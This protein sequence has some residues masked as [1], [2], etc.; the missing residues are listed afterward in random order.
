MNN[1]TTVAMKAF[2]P[3]LILSCFLF[4]LSIGQVKASTTTFTTDSTWRVTSTNFP[5]WNTIPYALNSSWLNSGPGNVNC[6]IVQTGVVGAPKIWYPA[7]NAFRTC[8]FRKKF[9]VSQL[10]EVKSAIVEIAAADSYILYVNGIAIASGGATAKTV[11]IPI[12]I[13]QCENVIAV[14]ARDVDAKCWWMAAK[15]TINSTPLTFTASSNSSSANPLCIGQTLNLTSTGY[16][17]A[18]YTWS[19]PN[20]FTSNQQNPSLANTTASASGTYTVV[21]SVGKCCRYSATVTVNLKEC[22]ECLD[23]IQKEIICKNGVYYETFCVKNN[24]T[25]TVNNINL[26]SSTPGVIYSPNILTPSAGLAPGQTYCKTVIVSGLGAVAG[27]KVCLNAMLVEIKQ[28]QQTWFCVSKEPLCVTLPACGNQTSCDSVKVNFTPNTINL[29]LGDSVQLNPNIN[30][31]TGLTYSWTPTTGLSNSSIKNPWAKPLVTTTYTLIVS[32]QGT[33]CKKDASVTVVVKQCPPSPVPCQWTVS[34]QDTTITVCKGNP[35]VLASAMSP[36]D[37]S[38]TVSWTS[39]P[40]SVITN[41]NSSVANAMPT[42]SPTIYT[43]TYSVVNS[44]GTICK[45]SANIKVLIKDCPPQCQIRAFVK[46]SVIRICAGTP[47][48]LFASSNVAG[49]TYSWSPLSSTTSASVT[50]SPSVTTI[51]TVTV[52]DP[53]TPN[54]TSSATVR[55]EV[56]ACVTTPTGVAPSS[57]RMAVDNDLS[58]EITIAPNPTQSFIS[59]QIPDS[60]NWK[61]ATLINSKGVVLN[62]F[63]RTDKAKSVKFDVQ[64]QPSGMYIISVKTDKGF[65]NKKVIKE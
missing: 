21:V 36:M 63:E 24:S 18:T 52:T 19:G 46:D 29:C 6:G 53:T 7:T 59:V 22:N 61:S 9:S 35:V 65:V 23:F 60:F 15:V 5:S 30:P 3:S 47:T 20:G 64:S 28:C 14:Q 55:V 8:Y 58:N 38:A 10:C 54:C 34:V 44:D 32:V 57:S 2:L 51:Y 17:G 62:E 25:H 39:S 31:L 41:A 13:L 12:Q 48:T 42:V 26:I 33:T 43:V 27:A 40:A 11:N 4:A 16:S 45:K 1:K 37:S 50:V 56:I 49:A